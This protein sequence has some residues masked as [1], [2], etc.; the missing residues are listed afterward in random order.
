MKQSKAI[1]ILFYCGLLLLLFPV[2]I[3]PDIDWEIEGDL[4]CGSNNEII[5]TDYYQLKANL[6][7]SCKFMDYYKCT[8]ELEADRYVVIAKEIS[9]EW[10]QFL[11]VSILAGRFENSLTLEEYRPAHQR[12]FGT[13]SIVS[14]YI[15]LLG[16]VNNNIGIMLYKKYKQKTLPFSYYLLCSFNPS[17]T[18]VQGDCGFLYHFNKKSSYL[19]FF[20]SYIPFLR[21]QFWL[22]ENAVSETHNVLFDLICAH[23]DYAFVYGIELTCGSNII[24]PLALVR[25]P[26]AEDRSFFIGGDAHIGYSLEFGDLKLI[27]GLR[28]SILFPEFTVPECQQIEIL[29]GTMLNIKDTWFIH[30]DIGLSINSLYG[31]D[32]Q[33]YTQLGVLWAADVRLKL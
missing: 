9:L 31:D 15:D 32:Q 7:F 21:H 11:Y 4:V 27:P 14:D 20:A 12:L 24:D 5:L 26:G 13:K 28:F 3:F 33:F 23:Y 25:I 2:L 30:G 16:Y 1:Q 19:G 10:E 29:Y 6:E 22:E 8:V 18:E 17:T